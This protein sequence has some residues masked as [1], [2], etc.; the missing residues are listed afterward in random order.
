[1]DLVPLV[2]T[3]TAYLAAIVGP[4]VLLPLFLERRLG[5]PYNSVRSRLLAWSTFIVLL[6]AVSL[7]STSVV[8]TW[9]AGT[10]ASLAVLLALA[11]GWDLYDMKTRR[12]P[13][14]RHP[15]R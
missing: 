6:L 13:Q 12:I 14:G 3:V 7:A 10:W 4:L 15:T 9:D 11:V 5:I 1:M 2:L 8:G